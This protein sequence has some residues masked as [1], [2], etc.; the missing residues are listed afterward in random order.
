MSSTA[1]APIYNPHPLCI[2]VPLSAS[3]ATLVIS[4]SFVHGPCNK[5]EVISHHGFDFHFPTDQ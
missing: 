2:R 5:C 1:A 4:C 3:S